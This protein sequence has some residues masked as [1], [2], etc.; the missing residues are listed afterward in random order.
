M[1]TFDFLG[2]LSKSVRVS[3]QW[4]KL[5]AKTWSTLPTFCCVTHERSTI[6]SGSIVR[7]RMLLMVIG[8]NRLARPECLNKVPFVPD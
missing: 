7:D 4:Q 6:Y 1:R 3:A 2:R 8:T 5:E